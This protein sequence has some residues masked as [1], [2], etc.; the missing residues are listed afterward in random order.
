VIGAV[1][2]VVVVL[3]VVGVV[4][5]VVVV[6]LVVDVVAGVAV[7][8]VVVVVIMIV[9]ALFT[10]DVTTDAALLVR[11]GSNVEL[12]TFV[13]VIANP[14][15]VVIGTLNVTITFGRQLAHQS[16]T[17]SHYLTLSTYLPPAWRS[18]RCTAADWCQYS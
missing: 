2:L 16:K 11:S 4:L 7:V 15:G 9:V 13:D 8:D 1:V 18:Q 14:G 6:V 17:K 5:V 12:D 3:V 10:I